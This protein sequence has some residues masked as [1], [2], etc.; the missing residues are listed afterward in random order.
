MCSNWFCTD[1]LNLTWSKN[2]L[3]W[4]LSDCGFLHYPKNVQTFWTSWWW[5]HWPGH[6]IP[7]GNFHHMFHVAFPSLH[8]DLSPKGVS[9]SYEVCILEE[10]LHKPSRSPCPL[11]PLSF[12]TSSWE[13]NFIFPLISINY[14]FEIWCFYLKWQLSGKELSFSTWSRYYHVW[15]GFHI[16]MPFLHI[17]QYGGRMSWLSDSEA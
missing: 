1:V 15:P 11:N 3:K 2:T 14:Y 6:I 9:V 10:K 7:V 13:N 16:H 17:C 8:Y 12:Q 4:S 5:P